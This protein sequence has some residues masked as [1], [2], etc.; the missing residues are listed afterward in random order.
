VVTAMAIMV[1]LLSILNG[2]PLY[3]DA[4]VAAQTLVGVF[5]LEVLFTGVHMSIVAVVE[6]VLGIFFGHFICL[7]L[8][9]GLR[10]VSFYLI[11]KV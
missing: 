7:R 1:C 4:Q 11:I 6:V 5:A 3:V 8:F 2:L 9:V 10:G